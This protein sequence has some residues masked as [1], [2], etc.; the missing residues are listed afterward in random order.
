MAI[1]CQLLATAWCGI[2]YMPT[3][4]IVM[5]GTNAALNEEGS[6]SISTSSGTWA[7]L[8][9][10]G[11]EVG[12][13]SF[14]ANATSI[15]VATSGTWTGGSAVAPGYYTIATNN[16][17]N[18]VVVGTVVI[19]TAS[20]NLYV[21]NSAGDSI[22]N[23]SAWKGPT[24]DRD[25]YNYLNQNFPCTAPGIVTQAGQ[26]KWLT[27]P[28]DS[29]RPHLLWISPG[30]QD[31][32]PPANLTATAYGTLATDLSAA[33][34]TGAWYE[35]PVNEFENCGPWSTAQV[36]SQ[37]NADAAAI[38]AVD[39]TA[40][41]IVPCSGGI[42]NDSTL[43]TIATILAGLNFTPSALS[44][45]GENSYQI[46]SNIPM[47]RARLGAIQAQLVASGFPHL[48]YWD[49]EAGINGGSYNVLQPRR[50]ARQVTVKRLV[51]ESF[52][53]THNYSFPVFDHTGSGLPMYDVEQ[54]FGGSNGPLRA[55][56]IAEHVYTE[57]LYGTTCSPTS[58][59]TKLSF[60]PVG[61][62]GD[63]MFMGSHYTSAAH[64]VIVLA[65]NGIESDTVTLALSSVTGVHAWDGWGNTRS[66]TVDGHHVTVA[67]DDL[68][69]YVFIPSGATA[70]VVDTGSGVLSLLNGCT[71]IA[72]LK[73]S[74]LDENSVSQSGVVNDGVFS[75]CNA[76]AAGVGGIPVGT[77]YKDTTSGGTLTFS[78]FWQNTSGE[79]IVGVAIQTAG[80]AW[81]QNGCSLIAFTVTAT[82]NGTPTEVYSYSCAS[83]V[84]PTVDGS[85]PI[86]SPSNGNS[87]DPCTMTT[88][89]TGPFGFII[90]ASQMSLNGGITGQL[91]TALKF[92]FTTVD[93]G[94]Q[95]TLAA[96]EAGNDWPGAIQLAEVQIYQAP[97]SPTAKAVGRLPFLI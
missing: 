81:Q 94:G 76:N 70:S 74:V 7:V 58:L 24:L 22:W 10:G 44:D 49:T 71:N 52:G 18:G 13:G 16:G 47:L 80:P 69:T 2:Y 95:P 40:K 60:G 78:S 72:M 8:D 87:S 12:S 34:I 1:T 89:W 25:Y 5:D 21:P 45:H 17:S 97:S 59:P 84:V 66:V 65:T 92:T 6:K 9:G 53:W 32:Y 29:A 93:Y 67:V 64:D 73:A 19:C 61:T 43:A 48:D 50:H 91:V 15:T 4:T 28:Q 62:L 36:I 41:F 96:S 11:N 68:L 90:P 20:S 23:L 86:P 77:P 63:S 35:L 14:S 56:A 88:W 82:I 79:Q 55:G 39:S 38:L 42:F 33:S 3:P 46:L 85:N 31:T 37:C 54:T 75:Q 51:M 30:T 83:A 27:G 26:D 57:A